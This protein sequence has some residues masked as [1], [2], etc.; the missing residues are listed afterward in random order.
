MPG[1]QCGGVE[2]HVEQGG[3]GPRLLF[4]NGSGTTVG[5]SRGMLERLAQASLHAYDGGHAFFCRTPGPGTRWWR[6]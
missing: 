4:C 1:I 2:L 6:F 3:R 5:T